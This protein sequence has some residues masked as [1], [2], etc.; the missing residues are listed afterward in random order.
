[1][2]ETIEIQSAVWDFICDTLLLDT[3]AAQNTVAASVKELQIKRDALAK[4]LLGIK[5]TY[6]REDEP[7]E[8][9]A[10]GLQLI[11]I[12]HRTREALASIEKEIE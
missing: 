8:Y 9:V 10:M 2:T 12:A 11:D 1:M 3:G 4:A 7:G 5:S 6:L